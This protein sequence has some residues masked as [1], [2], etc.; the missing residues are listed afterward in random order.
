[1]PFLEPQVVFGKWIE[2]TGPAGTEFIEADLVGEIEEHSSE[3]AIP[4]PAALAPY[5][6][7][8]EASEIRIVEGWGARLSAP[9]YLD[10][11]AWSL[12]K[13]EQEAQK[14]LRQEQADE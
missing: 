7:N 8:I 2:V 13:T 3:K 6:E 11:T 5:C 12:F 1:M 4:L 9:G 10:C 14:F